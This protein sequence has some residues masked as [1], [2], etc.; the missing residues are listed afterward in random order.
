M[1]GLIKLFAPWRPYLI[2][3]VGVIAVCGIGMSVASYMIIGEK[4]ERIAVTDQ[5]VKDMT[6]ALT[7]LTEATNAVLALRE[8]EQENTRLLQDKLALLD[9][10]S[11]ATSQQ[12]KEMEKTNAEVREYMA[13]PIP[14]DLRRLLDKQ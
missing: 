1:A 14:A 3:L 11:A 7:S 2:G 10:R 4:N 9:E 13:R 8:V 6:E 12:L 5:R